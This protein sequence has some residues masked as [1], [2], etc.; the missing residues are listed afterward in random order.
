MFGQPVAGVGDGDGV[1]LWGEW[2]ELGGDRRDKHSTLITCIIYFVHFK[3]S[4]NEC[5]SAPGLV[6]NP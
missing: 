5:N 6:S 4:V 1:S 2:V 3:A